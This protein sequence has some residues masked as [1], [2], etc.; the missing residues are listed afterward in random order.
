MFWGVSRGSSDE[1]NERLTSQFDLI[2][3]GNTGG[4]DIIDYIKKIPAVYECGD[5]SRNFSVIIN[6]F[7]KTKILSNSTVIN[8][9]NNGFV[10]FFGGQQYQLGHY[11]RHLYQ[12]VNYIDSQ[13]SFLFSKDEKYEYIKTLRAQMSNY[14]QALLFINSLTIM[15]RD[16]EY[17]NKD[18][19]C[20]ISEYNLIKNLPKKFI[21]NMQPQDYYPD[22]DFEWK[23]KKVKKKASLN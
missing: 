18:G 2:D 6:S 19:K 17:S 7:L 12:A 4:F 9:I 5:S 8:N 13:S 1:L 23:S 15:G 10:K 11:F 21:P 16:W 20:L 22:V 14:E 3:N